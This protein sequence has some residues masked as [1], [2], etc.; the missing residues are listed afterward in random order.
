M[1][2]GAGW[3]AP[4]RRYGPWIDPRG[5]LAKMAELPRLEG[6]AAVF[7]DFDGTLVELAAHPDAV[8]VGAPLRAALVRLTRR[9]DGSVAIVTGRCVADIDRMLA[10]LVLP[11]AGVHGAERRRSD[12]GWV[13]APLPRL[14]AARAHLR[15][16]CALDPRAWLEE[17]PGALALHFRGAD[18][19]EEP[20]R[21]AVAEAQALVGAD[22][23]ATLAGKKLFELRAADVHKGAAVRA[24]LA[25]APFLGRRPWYFGDD[26]TDEDAFVVVRALGGVTVKLGD[27]ETAAEYRLRAPAELHA[28]LR[29]LTDA[30]DEESTP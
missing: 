26:L 17:K 8:R 20:A 14:D 1:R 21:V 11:V 9:L 2:G 12:G 27:G 7:F 19:L 29:G 18:D 25:E 30:F 4:H 13:R 24:F 28:W 6:A 22:A 16:W 23:V 5:Y 15:A 3:P 10:P